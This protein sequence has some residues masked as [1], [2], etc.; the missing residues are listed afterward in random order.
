[1]F[2]P[3]S[4]CLTWLLAA[5]VAGGFCQAQ[6]TNPSFETGTLSGW[7]SDGDARIMTSSYGIT[8]T[9]GTYDALITNDQA[10]P[11]GT[12]LTA[13]LESFLNLAPGALNAANNGTVIEGSAIKQQFTAT[14]G[15]LLTFSFDFAI[16]GDDLPNSGYNDFAFASI[17]PAATQGSSVLTL[18]SVNSATSLSQLASGTPAYFDFLLGHTGYHTYSYTIPASGTYVL[19]LGVV[20]VGPGSPSDYQNTSG[21]KFLNDR[22]GNSGLLLDNFNLSTVPEPQAWSL[23]AGFG[24]CGLTVIRRLLR[25]RKEV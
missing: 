10:Q 4:K 6:L 24:L 16:R 3:I 5:G 18:A 12:A 23:V 7:T 22:L 21:S 11:A 20:D 1:M 14:A 9:A 17:Q 13:G 2:N 15:Q 8:P 25:G 19:G